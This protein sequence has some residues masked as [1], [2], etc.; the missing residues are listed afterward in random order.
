MANSVFSDILEEIVQRIRD[1]GYIAEAVS[2]DL[3]DQYSPKDNQVIV[4][5][6]GFTDNPLLSCQGNPPA[7]AFDASVS[8]IC[9]LRQSKVKD[10][11]FMEERLSD[12]SGSVISALTAGASWWQLGGNAIDTRIQGIDKSVE[13]D[14]SYANHTISVLVTYRTDE[15]DPFT[16]R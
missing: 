16:R 4:T 9:I 12:F 10:T 6:T 14:G 5:A 13:G 15:N 7:Q 11:K 2:P 3:L 8:L 1:G